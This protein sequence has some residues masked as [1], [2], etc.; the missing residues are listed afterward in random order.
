MTPPLPRVHARVLAAG[1]KQNVCRTTGGTGHG[2][3]C[4]FPFAYKGKKYTACTTVDNGHTPWCATSSKGGSSGPWGNCQKTALCKRATVRPARPS[5]P[6]DHFH[7][8]NVT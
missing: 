2:G 3:A 5:L 8:H 7:T 1:A 6:S 4:V